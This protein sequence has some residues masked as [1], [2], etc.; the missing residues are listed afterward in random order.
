VHIDG[1]GQRIHGDHDPLDG[2]YPV[3]LWDPGDVVV[4]E[5]KLDVPANYG[6]GDYTIYLGF[7]SGETRL[8]VEHGA[9]DGSNRAV[10]GVLRIQ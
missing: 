4:D 10:A 8:A 7:Y 3:R 9:S 5:Q 1:R 2:K 6:R